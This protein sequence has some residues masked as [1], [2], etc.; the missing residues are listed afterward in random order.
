[1][2]LLELVDNLTPGV[3][4]TAKHPT[5]LITMGLNVVSISYILSVIRNSLHYID[6]C[7]KAHGC[8]L[9]LSLLQI[10]VCMEVCSAALITQNAPSDQR[11]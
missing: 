2:K 6:N 9:K 3:S 8:V 1:M 5:T 11:Q 4:A 7:S 10:Q